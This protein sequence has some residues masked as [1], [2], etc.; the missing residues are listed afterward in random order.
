MS[1]SE[2]FL[3]PVIALQWLLVVH[4]KNV[5]YSCLIRSND[6]KSYILYSTPCTKQKIAIFVHVK[7]KYT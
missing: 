4:E 6:I 5:K 1:V 2:L 3:K 7:F